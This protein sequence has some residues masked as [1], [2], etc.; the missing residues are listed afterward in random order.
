MKLTQQ[1]PETHLWGI[2]NILRGK[3]ACQERKH[4]TLSQMLYERRCDQWENE[5]NE[6]IVEQQRQRGR[7]FRDVQ[8]TFTAFLADSGKPLPACRPCTA[9][10]GRQ[11][12][13]ADDRS[14]DLVS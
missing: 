11:R 10:V 5:C 8:R 13:S 1:Q 14:L 2:A 6:A 9:M 7:T 12:T 4:Y 3:T